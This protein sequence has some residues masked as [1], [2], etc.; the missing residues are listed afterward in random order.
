MIH[1]NKIK[2]SP[3]TQGST[4]VHSPLTEGG[5]DCFAHVSCYVDVDTWEFQVYT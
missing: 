2:K 4:L 1:H 3:Q 5:A